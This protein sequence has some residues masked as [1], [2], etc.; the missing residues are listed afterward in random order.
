MGDKVKIY[1]NFK[2][3]DVETTLIKEIDTDSI[4]LTKDDIFYFLSGHV[5]IINELYEMTQ[6]FEKELDEI[7]GK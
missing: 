7:E 2:H 6:E 4:N 5:D 3:K 1:I